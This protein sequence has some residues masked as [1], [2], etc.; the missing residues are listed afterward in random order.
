MMVRGD[1]VT[2]IDAIVMEV[3]EAMEAEKDME[4][5]MVVDTFI[6]KK[7]KVRPVSPVALL[8]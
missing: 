3:V 1:I 7:T 6:S 8:T 5:D 2:M 4:I